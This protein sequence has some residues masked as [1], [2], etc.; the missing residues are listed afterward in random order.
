M[1]AVRPFQAVA[2][3]DVA[4]G[5]VAGRRIHIAGNVAG[6]TAAF[7]FLDGRHFEARRRRLAVGRQRH[8]DHRDPQSLR[9]EGIIDEIA[10]GGYGE[11][12]SRG[13]N[14]GGS[15]KSVDHFR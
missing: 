11:K 8:K 5:E 15:T 3:R 10:S 7:G 2:Q 13:A 14:C 9:H 1:Q 12:D 4:H 6:W